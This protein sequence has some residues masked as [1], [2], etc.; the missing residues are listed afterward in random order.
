M[1]GG[2]EMITHEEA[3]EL[4]KILYFNINE[5]N[6]RELNR[7]SKIYGKLDNYITQQEKLQAEHEELKRDMK[8]FMELIPE[9]KFRPLQDEVYLL[10]QKLSKVGKEE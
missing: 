3:L 10:Q 1:V 2:G 5:K 9:V 8:R 7:T 4:V 6:N